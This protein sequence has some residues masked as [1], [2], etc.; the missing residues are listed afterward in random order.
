M[1]DAELLKTYFPLDYCIGCAERVPCYTDPETGCPICLA[2][3]EAECENVALGLGHYTDPLEE[4]DLT[5]PT[6]DAGNGYSDRTNPKLRTIGT[7]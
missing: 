6:P 3:I 2:C 4:P 7:R 5:F 1:T